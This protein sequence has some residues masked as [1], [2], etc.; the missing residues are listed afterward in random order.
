MQRQILPEGANWDQLDASFEWPVPQQLNIAELCCD[1]WARDD[2]GRCAL[3]DAS[4][5]DRRWSYGALADASNRLAAY[6][7]RQGVGKGDRVALLLPQSAGV[8]VTHFAAYKLG[9]VVVPLFSLF[10]ADALRYR[11]ADSGAVML[12]TD[13]AG[14]EKAAPLRADLPA[15]GH[16]VCVDGAFW[17]MLA[18]TQPLGQA[19]NTRADDPAMLIYTSGT[20]GPPKGVLHAH[21]FLIGHLPSIELTHRGFPQP[22]DC[23]WTPAD[24]AW[25]GGLMDM[26]MP[27][28]YYGV[29]LVSQRMR[30]FDAAAAWDL[31]ARLGIRNMFLPPTALRRMR[32]VAVP[33]GVDVRS[34]SSGGE[35]LG[36]DLLSWGRDALGVEISEIYGQTECNLVAAS[37]PARCTRRPA[38]LAARCRAL[39]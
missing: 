11:L 18:E 26:A 27:C 28:L 5:G 12:V 3:I 7:R 10:G 19:V 33:A 39:P 22:G 25:I 36:P 8:L 17:E 32:Q 6:M 29:P 34:I 9:A 38:P 35:A 24:W 21:R 16:V 15:L 30:K 2:P 1:S 31:I 14:L 20:T 37:V 23:G 13:A 4:D